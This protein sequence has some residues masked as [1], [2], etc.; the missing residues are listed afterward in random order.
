[1]IQLDIGDHRPIYEQIK[2]KLKELIIGGVLKEGDKLPSVRE[3]A[4]S[5]TI[6][7]NTIQKAYRELEAEGYIYSM[8]AK[9]SFV[10]KMEN[11]H[12]SSKIA[13]LSECIYASI[14]EMKFLGVEKDRITEI[15]NKI[16]E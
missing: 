13:E 7:P 10:S 9:G 14:M 12:D 5:L 3:L 15:I 11:N 16:Y 8:A 6:N 4:T 1:M 2:G